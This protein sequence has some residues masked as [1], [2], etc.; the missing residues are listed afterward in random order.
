MFVSSKAIS[1]RIRT[2]TRKEPTRQLK[3]PKILATE[4]AL[5][6]GGRAL[7]VAGRAL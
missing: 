2:I 4:S 3:F 1:S 6:A 7:D 5:K